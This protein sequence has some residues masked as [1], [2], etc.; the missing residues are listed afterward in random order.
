[1]NEDYICTV[2][3]LLYYLFFTSSYLSYDFLF[4]YDLIFLFCLTCCF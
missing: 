1:M 2:L 3:F 4:F